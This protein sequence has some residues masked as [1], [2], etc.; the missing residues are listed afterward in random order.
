MIKTEHT[1]PVCDAST[2]ALDVVD[3]N[4]NCEEARGGFLPISGIPIYYYMCDEC[5]FCFAP[6]IYQWSKDEFA[7]KI[8]NE[9]YI[10]VDPDYQDT[11]PRNK[12][13]SLVK[14]FGEHALNIKHLDYGGGA[15][16]LSELLNEAGWQST[17]YDPFY[18]R[19]TSVE[20]LG[21]FDLITAYEVFEHVP[22]VKSLIANLLSL[23]NDEGVIL[24]STLIS[25]GNIARR[26]RISWWYASPRNG[27]I[28]LFSKQ[29]LAILATRNHLS[30]GS[31][32]SA[33]HV[34][35]NKVPAWASHIL[36]G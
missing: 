1:C 22:D 20:D 24:F 23:L 16:L 26:Q 21:K 34:L 35:W 4:K 25:D 27:H 31:F 12:A 7:E 28:S 11:R 29:S 14:T 6:E 10:E 36:R 13:I 8:Y 5:D 17:S 30:L 33:N 9:R 3:F 18:N 15:G 2:S 19:D 32:S